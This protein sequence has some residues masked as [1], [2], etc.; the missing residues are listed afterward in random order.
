MPSNE[1]RFETSWRVEAS[2]ELVTEILTDAEGLPRWWPS[3]Y[4]SVVEERPDVYALHTRGWL[5]YT[6]RWN[7]TVTSTNHPHGFALRAWGDLEGY[8]VC[9]FKQDGAWTN[10]HYQWNVLAE[11]PLL[12]RLSFLLK[13]IFAANHR[14][15]MA[16][17]EQSLQREIARL[18]YTI[19]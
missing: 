17:G 4:L 15:A 13:P 16:L 10:I 11:K 19:V 2:C 8:G 1:Y 18:R 5:P 9:T 6:L 3:V 7:F 12:R 14:W